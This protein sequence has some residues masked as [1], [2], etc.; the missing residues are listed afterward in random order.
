MTSI[1]KYIVILVNI[2]AVMLFVKGHNEPGGGFIAG[3]ITAM[4]L[5]MLTMIYGVN[6]TKD[7]IKFNPLTMALL[8]VLLTYLTGL[9]PV[10]FNQPFMMHHLWTTTLPIIGKVDIG[11][12]IIFDFGIYLVVVGAVSKIIMMLEDTTSCR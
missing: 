5:V 2:L 6:H 4:S 11:T 12:P 7:L 10:L 9:I 3:C 1:T 8:G